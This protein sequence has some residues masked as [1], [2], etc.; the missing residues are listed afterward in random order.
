LREELENEFKNKFNEFKVTL[1]K[2]TGGVFEIMVNEHLQIFSKKE[3][4]RF[5]NSSYEIIKT[6]NDSIDEGR[7][8]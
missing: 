2:G 7:L 5:P 4:N 3:L 6:I 1:I 8:G